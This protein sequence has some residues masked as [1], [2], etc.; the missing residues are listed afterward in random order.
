MIGP[1]WIRPQWTGIAA[2]LIALCM[3]VAIS[4]CTTEP[5]GSSI[6]VEDAWV[7]PVL[8]GNTTAAYMTIRN[9]GDV[10]DRL[11]SVNV[12]A[13]V[14]AEIHETVRE[15]DLVRMVQRSQGLS[16]PAGAEVRLEPGATHVMLID[17]AEDLID[18][19]TV[20]LTLSFEQGGV[21]V[22]NAEVRQEGGG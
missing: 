15:G 9:Q 13:A 11:L 18:G 5:T 3:A 22:V 20:P 2:A 17:V 4:A 7:R 10:A 12:E 8:S 21:V 14:A 6:Q 16:I 1:Q 19:A